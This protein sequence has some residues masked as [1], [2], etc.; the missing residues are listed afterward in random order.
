MVP[1]F[2]PKESHEFMKKWVNNQDWLP[3]NVK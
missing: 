3:Y 2:K 1:L